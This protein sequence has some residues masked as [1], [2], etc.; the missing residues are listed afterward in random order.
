M[1][2]II[3][4][5]SLGKDSWAEDLTPS[6][7]IRQLYLYIQCMGRYHASAS[8]G[9]I[10]RSHLHSYLC[11]Y[12]RSGCGKILYQ[13]KEAELPA[14]CSAILNCDLPHSYYA[15]PG[16]VWDFFWIH[17][18]GSC[19]DG[20][21]TEITEHWDICRNTPESLLRELFHSAGSGDI[22]DAIRSS[23]LLIRLCSDYLI[24]LKKTRQGRDHMLSPLVRNALDYLEENFATA[25]SLDELC[26]A[27]SVSKY[28]LAHCFKEQTRFSP[29]EYL[30][31]RRLS[32]AKSLLRSTA[33]PIGQIASLCGFS[34]ASYFIQTFKKREGMTPGDY[35]QYFRQRSED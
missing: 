13:Q 31:T 9:V 28:Y 3:P 35:R 14:G 6:Q 19:I 22:T 1:R 18:S 11:L 7:E 33:Q 20:Y 4:Y 25:L 29:Y 15:L 34:S 21:L 12:T 32:Y 23:T 17:F 26:R 16:D 30:I 10:G 8:Y 2:T 27:L 24:H 5:A